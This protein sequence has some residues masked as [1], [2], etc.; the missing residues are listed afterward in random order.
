ML[1]S[2]GGITTSRSRPSTADS[3]RARRRCRRGTVGACRPWSS[4][5]PDPGWSSSTSRSDGGPGDVLV[6][7]TGDG[8]LRH[9]PAHRGLGRLGRNDDHR[10]AG[11]RATSSSARSSRSAANVTD[12]QVGDVVSGEGHVV[13]GRCRNCLAGRRHLCIHTTGVGR[14]PRR[15][16]RRV[17]RPADDQ[18]LGA[19]AAD[20][21][22]TWRRSS[23]RSAT[24]C[25]PR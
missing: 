8:H 14:Q 16:V 12:L 3:C 1:S 22:R 2:A 5:S 17:R 19:P 23:T 4:A 25:T 6:R 9:R 7:G 15:R 24:R 13:C 10:A 20:R 21:P 18:R 11:R